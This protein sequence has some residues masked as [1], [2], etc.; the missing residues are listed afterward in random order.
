M[1][2]T[3]NP[4]RR[5]FENAPAD[6]ARN[7]LPDRMISADSHIIEPPHTYTKYIDPTFRGRAPKIGKDRAGGDAFEVE[8]MSPIVLGSVA[9]AGIDPREITPI[10]RQFADLPRGGLGSQAALGRSGPRRHCRGG[11]LSLSRHG[12]VQSQGRRFQARVHVGL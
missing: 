5:L 3:L 6:F 9:A 2:E 4:V 7:T 10:G 1:A 8:G 12:A 11:H